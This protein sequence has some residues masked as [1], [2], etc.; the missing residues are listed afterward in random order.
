MVDD[1]PLFLDSAKKMLMGEPGI[2]IVGTGLSGQQ[3]LDQVSALH[4]DLVVMDLCMPEM[5]GLEATRKLKAQTE[6]PRVVIVTLE[7]DVVFRQAA[8]KE[9]A[10]GFLSKTTL[11]GML[12][13]LIRK[14]FE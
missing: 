6:S 11:P 14:L 12:A 10:D 9:G 4:P 7:D 3:A 1:N 8:C 5:D 2:E 13:P